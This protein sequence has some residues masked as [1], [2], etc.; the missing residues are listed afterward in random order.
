MRLPW[1][2]FYGLAGD[3]VHNIKYTLIPIPALMANRLINNFSI[4][5][6]YKQDRCGS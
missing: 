1:L 4:M 2:S 6:K 5:Y 3:S